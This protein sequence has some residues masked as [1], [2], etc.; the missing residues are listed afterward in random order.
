VEDTVATGLG[1]I[2]NNVSCLACHSAPAAGGTIL[3]TRFGRLVRGQFDP[4]AALGGSLLQDRAIDPT[5]SHPP[6]ANVIAKPMTTPLFGAGLTEGIAD[7]AI[8]KN[9]WP[10]CPDGIA[11][12]AAIVT[13]VTTAQQRVG[14]RL[15]LQ[16]AAGHAPRLRGQ[17]LAERD[18]HHEPLLPP[19][20]RAA[21]KR[22]PA[23]AVRHRG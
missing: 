20:E 21:P 22:R 18:R 17:C 14:L 9:A 3:E 7:G 19:G 4:L 11:G 12:R 13:E 5:G 1:P 23:G 15:R 10:P 2:F 16:G 8:L 6:E